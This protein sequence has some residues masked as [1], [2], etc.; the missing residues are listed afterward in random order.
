MAAAA[1]LRSPP[2][3]PLRVAGPNLH[4]PHPPMAEELLLPQCHHSVPVPG[5]ENT[6]LACQEVTK[7]IKVEFQEL[8]QTMT[9]RHLMEGLS[10]CVRDVFLGKRVPFIKNIWLLQPVGP[11][12]TWSP[13]APRGRHCPPLPLQSLPSRWRWEFPSWRSG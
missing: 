6:T 10:M 13:R 11:S 7:N 4:D 5:A 8:L 12:V 3:G 9:T 2:A 1:R